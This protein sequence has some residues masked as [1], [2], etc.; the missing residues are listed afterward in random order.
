MRIFVTGAPGWLGDKLIETLINK[1]HEVICLTLP[2][3]RHDH[4]KEMGAEI[5][6][7]DITNPETLKNKT[8]E[9][10]TVIHAAGIIHPQLTKASDFYRINTDG[11]QHM[12]QEAVN[13]NVEHFIY[14]SS[15]SAVGV[16]KNRNE[17]MTETT[18]PRP[19]TDYG[20]S[21]YK[22]E[23]VVKGYQNKGDIDTTI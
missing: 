6:I 3:F 20:K 1:N 11:T 16:N 14:I 22:A 23:Q 5:V 13:Q 10:D 8:R 7:G 19:Y 9:A 2:Q 21:K 17:L 18:T 15:N 12:I 4:L